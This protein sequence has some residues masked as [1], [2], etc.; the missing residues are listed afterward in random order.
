M[1]HNPSQK[2]LAKENEWRKEG[3]YTMEGTY[4]TVEAVTETAREEAP[5]ASWSGNIIALAILPFI[6]LS[7]FL[8]MYEI[9]DDK[10]V[11]ATFSGALVATI[12]PLI[13]QSLKQ[14]TLKFGR[15]IW[16][17]NVVSL[18][19]F[20]IPWYRMLLY[21]ILIAV[22]VTQI[23]ALFLSNFL[24]LFSVLQDSL[25]APTSWLIN[26]LYVHFSSQQMPPQLTTHLSGTEAES[27]VA[28]ATGVAISYIIVPVILYFLGSWI[29][30]RCN[31]LGVF[32]VIAVVILSGYINMALPFLLTSE[33]H[34]ET[35][36]NGEEKSFVLFLTIALSRLSLDLW[37][38][39]F[40]LVGF[41]HGRRRQMS[42]YLR[43]L[44]SHLSSTDREAMID[45]AYD[46]VKEKSSECDTENCVR[47][48]QN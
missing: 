17:R 15:P 12:Y 27:G 2:T 24:N 9:I 29:G 43:Y 33:T 7:A 42:S 6:A 35:L 40:G 16:P 34:F 13:D 23:I 38:A 28:V 47:E 48:Y 41:W 10:S 30:S 36:H 1:H 25:H 21:G 39:L 26:W 22:G 18:E 5:T 46:A 44:L 19:S 45:M 32:V 8:I 37:Q 4:T 14:R 3:N 20:V 11:A 31:R